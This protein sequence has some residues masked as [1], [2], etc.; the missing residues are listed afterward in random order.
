MYT[1]YINVKERYVNFANEHDFEI[2]PSKFPS[3]VVY[4]IE[5]G[6]NW[7]VER[8]PFRGQ[9]KLEEVRLIALEIFKEY[10]DNE[11]VQK[12]IKDFKIHY[13]PEDKYY[14]RKK[15]DYLLNQAQ[16][17]MTQLANMEEQAEPVPNHLLPKNPNGQY[18][19]EGN[20]ILIKPE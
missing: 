8:D 9:E 4:Y 7:W 6:D 18:D 13:Q 3:D 2:D 16:Q 11:V 10:E 20:E 17:F 19:E 15:I 14:L 1:R 5:E 12:S